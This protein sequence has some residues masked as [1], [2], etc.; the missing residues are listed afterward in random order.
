MKKINLKNLDLYEL[1]KK[2]D[3]LDLSIDAYH[4]KH[5]KTGASIIIMQT[6]DDNKVF[7]IGFKTPPFDNTGLPH[8]LEHSVLCGSKKYPAK[9]PFVELVKGSLNTFLNAMTYPDKTIYPVASCNNQDFKNLMDVYLDAV[10][11]PNIYNKKE[12]FMQEGFHYHMENA[13]DDIIYNGVVYNEMKGAF[14][15]PESILQRMITHELYKDTAYAFESGGDPEDIPKLTYEEFLKFHKEYYHPSNSFIMLYGDMDF[16][17]RLLFLDR[18]YL[19]KYEKIEVNAE[20][21]YQEAFTKPLYKESFYPLSDDESEEGKHFFSYAVSTDTALI[22]IEYYAMKILDYALISMPGAP[23]KKALIEKGIGKDV[24]GGY[25]PGYRQN[26]FV[27]TAKNANKEELD[28][29]LSTISDTLDKLVKEGIDK[30]SLRAGIN[31]L[32][33]QYKEGDFGSYPKGLFYCLDML[34]SF[35]YDEDKAFSL[36]NAGKIFDIL[37]E[38]TNTDYFE[39]LIEKYLINNNHKLIYTLIPKKGLAKEKTEKLTNELKAYK[40]GL[41][42]LEKEKLIEETNA[43]IKYQEEPSSKED[44]E[45]I[46]MIKVSDIDELPKDFSIDLREEFGIGVVFSNL[47]SNKIA[48]LKLSFSADN[49]PEELIPYL[50]LLDSVMAYMDTK[51][52]NYQDLNNEI[53]LHS[54]GASTNVAIY[55]QGDN[56]GVKLNFEG[57]IKV[58]YNEISF[59][60]KIL[61]EILLNTVYDSKKRLKEI[62]DE[63]ISRLRMKLTSQGHVM[64]VYRAQSYIHESGMLTDML[65]GIGAYQFYEELSKGYDENYNEIINKLYEVSK[66][67]FT[68]SNLSIGLTC[69]EEG[70]DIAKKYIEELKKDLFT[71]TDKR[72]IRKLN[73]V[74]KN[75]AFK[76]TSEVSYVARSGDFSKKGYKYA[77]NLEALKNILDYEYLWEN[78]RVRGGAYGVMTN[79]IR[80]SSIASLV[81]YRDPNVLKTN[82]IY[83]TVPEYLKN[84]D[85]DERDMDKFI[86]GTISS[87][88]TP[89]TPRTQ[90]SRSFNAYMCNT[91]YEDIKKTRK[92]V[93]SLTKEDVRDASKVV[94][95]VLDDGV[96]C[97]IGN[98]EKIE[99]A[100]ELFKEVKNLF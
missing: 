64:A 46:P 93:I 11:N 18:E 39:K 27:I 100:K 75:E 15:T 23:I 79:W 99:E 81:S 24:T 47:N 68:P 34:D 71:D 38:N 83:E 44:L 52:Y 40:D 59:A 22:E 5:K 92:E 87:F 9:D 60:F 14:S 97:V 86:I 80:N 73:P 88:D 49:I 72:Y 8:I 17:E 58:F 53:N 96:I 89:K 66:L 67:I 4:L 56:K 1:V 43:F 6:D 10:F 70:Y 55:V 20:L 51:N 62:I 65:N 2:E 26:P 3:I 54:G 50:G 74:V 16:E 21:G 63:N 95:A 41:T 36:I 35:L 31:I 98:A 12:I 28:D 45:K 85:A 25:N 48:Y 91:T 19:S 69:D 42:E 29:F 61:K 13:E 94:K 37:L 90:G 57:G 76:T 32:K 82:E 7:N 33:F 84:F 78:V 77:G 30:N